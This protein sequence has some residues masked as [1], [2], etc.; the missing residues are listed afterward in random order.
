MRGRSGGAQAFYDKLSDAIARRCG[1]S[2]CGNEGGVMQYHEFI[3]RVQYHSGFSDSES[4]EATRVFMET[5]AARL[6]FAELRKAE[7]QLPPEIV[8][9]ATPNVGKFEKFH[10]EEFLERIATKQNISTA[11]AKKQ[12]YSVWETLKEAL[13]EGQIEHLRAQLPNDMVEMLH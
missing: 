9:M 6:T 7:S 3:K 12:M 11:H 4:V 5:L 10:G 1:L 2:F 8:D 13:D